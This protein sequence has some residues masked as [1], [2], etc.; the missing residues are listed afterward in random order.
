MRQLGDHAIVLGAGV[1]GLLTARVLTDCYDQVSIV[2]RDALPSDITAR[3]G[4]PQGRHA[5]VM[6]PRGTQ[7]LDELF[8]DLVAELVADGAVVAEPLAD[9]RFTVGGHLLRSAPIGAVAVQS[10]RP[11]LESHLR[12]RLR[13]SG[14]VRIVDGCDVV[15]LLTD[16]AAARVTGVRIMHR[17]P[18]STEESLAG[19]LVVDALG[20]GGRTP[21]WL[22][23]LGYARP[24]EEAPRVD[25]A[26]A[27]MP[28]RLPASAVGIERTV[29]VGPVAG[30]PRGMI[31]V[32]VEDG[33]RMLTVMGLGAEHRPPSDPLALLDFVA[34]FA[35]PDVLTALRSAELLR[36]VATYRY[37]SY[38]RRRYDTMR[39]FPDGLVVV[40]DAL[41]S[42][43]PIYAQGMTVAAQEAIALRACLIRGTRKLA[44]RFFR[45]AARIIADPWRA[46]VSADLALPEVDGDRPLSVRLLNRYVDRV[47]TAAESDDVVARQFM[48]VTGL[49]DSPKSLFCAG[50]AARVLIGGGRRELVTAP[51][52]G[53]N[54]VPITN[55][56]RGVAR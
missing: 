38:L 15:G 7:L 28:V 4:V 3:R 49:L 21:A 13:R 33:T 44:P 30:R 19:D 27:T 53:A 9:F 23:S 26:Y 25:V 47:L 2:E 52:P 29:G 14:R 31:L 36:E 1:A 10:S 42:F 46:A 18:G 24:D 41:C 40:G 45:K 20:R 11:F 34:D 39:R 16:D 12:E 17:E 55:N 48:R 5:H 8:P 54:A 6:M 50:I 37:P 22:A 51:R 32:E 35:P 56:S 43:S